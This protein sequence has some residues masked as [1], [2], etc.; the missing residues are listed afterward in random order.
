MFAE[1]LC[2]YVDLPRWWIGSRVTQVH[3]VSAPNLASPPG[4][5]DNYHTTYRFANGAVTFRN[6]AAGRCR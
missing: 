2:H 1:K 3:S 5:R 4:V 6:G